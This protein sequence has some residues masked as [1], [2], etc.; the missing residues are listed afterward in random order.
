LH[1]DGH[2]QTLLGPSR[3]YLALSMSGAS[4][5]R[6]H[7]KWSYNRGPAWDTSIRARL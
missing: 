7:K 2:N 1:P 5:G 3:I 6:N 4:A